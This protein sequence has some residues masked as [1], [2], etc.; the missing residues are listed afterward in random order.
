MKTM[1]GTVLGLL[2]L[3]GLGVMLWVGGGHVGQ[4]LGTL[5]GRM[6][7]SQWLV[8]GSVVAVLAVLQSVRGA[9]RRASADQVREVRRPVYESVAMA[10]QG[11]V[12]GAGSPPADWTSLLPRDLAA[13][14]DLLAMR[15]SPA[16]LRDYQQLRELAYGSGQ[17][18]AQIQQQLT[19]LMLR[20][21]RELDVSGFISMEEAALRPFVAEGS[22]QPQTAAGHPRDAAEQEAVLA[23]GQSAVSL[24]AR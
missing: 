22:G 6:E 9:R 1:V 4:W 11:A 13:L 12:R 2:L 19:R 20:M 24:A 14:E 23:G 7:P 21:R 17:S 8:L 10:W 15:A 5:S 16:V 18:N 3:A